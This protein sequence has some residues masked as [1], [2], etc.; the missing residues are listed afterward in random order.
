MTEPLATGAA[1]PVVTLRAVGGANGAGNGAGGTA[2]SVAGDVARV[3][4]AERT[5][6]AVGVDAAAATASF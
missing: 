3:A 6:T 5:E 4:A 1:D 2:V